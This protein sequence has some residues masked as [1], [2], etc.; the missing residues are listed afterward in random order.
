MYVLA[1]SDYKRILKHFAADA[2]RVAPRQTCASY[3]WPRAMSR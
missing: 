3:I 2:G 1:L